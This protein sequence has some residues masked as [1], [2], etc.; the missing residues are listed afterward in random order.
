MDVKKES[1]NPPPA[2]PAPAYPPAAEEQIWRFFWRSVEIIR[3]IAPLSE[4]EESGCV[5]LSFWHD[6]EWWTHQLPAQRLPTGGRNMEFSLKGR[7]NNS[8]ERATPCLVS[9]VEFDSSAEWYGYH[10][11][12]LS[13]FIFN[14]HA[15]WLYHRG[16]HKSWLVTHPGMSWDEGLRD[17]IEVLDK[18]HLVS[19]RSVSWDPALHS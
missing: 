18:S 7:C 6:G 16:S 14:Q 2:G 10:I 4:S 5:V 13:V 15:V 11:V 9:G 19:S 1:V 8:R 17:E 3:R 12:G